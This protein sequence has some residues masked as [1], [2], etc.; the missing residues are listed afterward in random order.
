MTMIRPEAEMKESGVQWIGDIP[1]DWNTKPL[2]ACLDEINQK[3]NP[4]VTTNILSLTNTDGVI[5][6]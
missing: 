6:Y 1:S 3:N 5:P 2:Y 4:V